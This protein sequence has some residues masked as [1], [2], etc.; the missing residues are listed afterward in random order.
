MYRQTGRAAAGLKNLGG[1]RRRSSCSTRPQNAHRAAQ[2]RAGGLVITGMFTGRWFATRLLASPSRRLP[3]EQV[4]GAHRRPYSPKDVSFPLRRR[5][6]PYRTRNARQKRRRMCSSGARSFNR[7]R[8]RCTSPPTG[9]GRVQ[10]PVLVRREP[11]PSATGSST[12]SAD[13]RRPRLFTRRKGSRAGVAAGARLTSRRQGHGS[14]GAGAIET[15]AMLRCRPASGSQGR[16]SAVAAHGQVQQSPGRINAVL[17]FR[18][19][20]RRLVPVPAAAARRQHRRRSA[21][22]DSPE[23]DLVDTVHEAPAPAAGDPA[24]CRPRIAGESG[25]VG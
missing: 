10:D 24:E 11:P 25:L 18:P 1:V 15:A 20:C 23:A 21:P 19:Q 16:L 13:R 2:P 22:P 17:A 3:A 9:E 14:G 7:S 8:T 4:G 12:D 5:S 6:V